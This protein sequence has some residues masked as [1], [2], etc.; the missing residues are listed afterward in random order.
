MQ[1][2]F[3]FRKAVKLDD[4]SNVEKKKY[5]QKRSIL[6]YLYN[7]GTVAISDI[8]KWTNLSIPS[9]TR[10]IFELI[11]EGY[12]KEEGIGD[13]VGGRRPNLYGIHPES[14]YILG[15]EIGRYISRMKIVNI[16]NEKVTGLV[17]YRYKLQNNINDIDTIYEKAQDL[18]SSS[19]I[20]ADKLISTGMSI[21]GL[22]NSKT[23]KSYDYFNFDKKPIALVFEEKFGK[24]VYIE[25]DSRI[26]ALGELF[27]GL[28]KGKKNVLCL[29]VG[30]SLGLGMIFNGRTYQGKSGFAG[31]LGHIQTVHD[32]MLCYCGKKGCL[33][34]VAS[35]AAVER[36][37]KEGIENG[38]VSLISDIVN[39]TTED[40]NIEVVIDAANKE[41]QFAIEVISEAGNHLGRGV[42]ILIHLY[43][44][45]MIIMGGRLAKADQYLTIPLQQVLNK[46]TISNIRNDTEIVTSNLGKKAG[47][48]GAIALVIK[49][50]FDSELNTEIF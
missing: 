37:A 31:E 14:G 19:G 1:A 23:G 16:L 24:P 34:T 6:E 5:F 28:A 21:P 43:N 35:G 17:E 45:E 29:N 7:N 46:D 27:F 48:M 8:C 39:N 47:V 44:P 2:P 42:A 22:I 15:V 49:N 38:T 10:L 4:L 13:S 40:I 12:L 41:D 50:I 26:M 20:D 9:V 30:Y 11:N 32:G 33:E 3:I 25:N 18:I 36:M